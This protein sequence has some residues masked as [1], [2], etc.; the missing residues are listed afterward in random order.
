MPS[1]VSKFGYGEINHPDAEEALWLYTLFHRITMWCYLTRRGDTSVLVSGLDAIATHPR[2]RLPVEE[3]QVRHLAF[4]KSLALP[5][6]PI[7]STVVSIGCYLFG[8]VIG[9]ERAG[10][11]PCRHSPF[12]M[13]DQLLDKTGY[14]I[15]AVV[16]KAANFALVPALRLRPTR[17]FSPSTSRWRSR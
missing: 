11:Q 16:C 1:K 13:L 10:G 17:T 7:I 12:G 5:P 4:S 3:I 15:T 8:I 14:C 2:S 9:L 6:V